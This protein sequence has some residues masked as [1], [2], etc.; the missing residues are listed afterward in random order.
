MKLC[1]ATKHFCIRHTMYTSN[2]SRRTHKY[3][4]SRCFVG[5]MLALVTCAFPRMDF[6]MRAKMTQGDWRWLKMIEDDSRWLEMTQD[7]SRWLKMTPQMAP[8]WP[9]ET[10]IP[11]K[12]K[13]SKNTNF[14]GTPILNE[15]IDN[16]HAS[17]MSKK[18]LSPSWARRNPGMLG[19]TRY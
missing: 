5:D 4:A 7:D 12:L 3:E 14:G 10:Q 18:A 1:Y 8:R 15:H 16:H 6:C 13:N 17:L 19:L 9:S 2:C 11:T